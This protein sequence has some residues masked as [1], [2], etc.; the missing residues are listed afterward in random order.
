MVD[1]LVERKEKINQA[2]SGNAPKSISNDRVVSDEALFNQLG[3][4]IKRNK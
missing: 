2:L 4:K 1:K 3:R